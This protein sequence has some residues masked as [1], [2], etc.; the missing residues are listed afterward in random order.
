[1]EI[2]SRPSS[3]RSLLLCLTLGLNLA[4]AADGEPRHALA[5]H[6]E[7]RYSADFEH[8][9]YVEPNAPQGGTLRLG[10]LGSFD[11]LNPYIIHGV[12]AKGHRLIFESLLARSMDEPFTLYGLI[13][14]SIELAPDRTW[15]VF[16][17]NPA[18][19]FH[20]GSP[21]TADDVL[22]SWELLKSK[23]R[24][25]IRNYYAR[26]SRAEKLASR[27]VRFS[28]RPGEQWEM[29]LIMGL[30]PVL[31]E[32][33]FR[34]RKFDETTLEPPLASGPYR[35]AVVDPGRSITYRRVSPYWGEELPV[36]RGRYNFDQVHYDYYRDANVAL[37][38]FKAG[39]YD[40]RIEA[41]PARWAEGYDHPAVDAGRIVR[42]MLEHG[43][44][45]GMFGLVFNT[46]RPPFDD[47]R[48]R[49]ALAV[50]FDFEWSNR[51]LFHGG[52]EQ[53]RSYFE[54][55]ELAA[56]GP[57]DPGE[58]RLLTPFRDELPEA[59]LTE[60]SVPEE[61]GREGEF[62]DRLRA[63]LNLLAE[64]GWLVQEGRMARTGR[65][66][67]LAFEILLG[68]PQLERVVLPYARNLA[69]AGIQARV[70]TVDSAQYHNRTA[71]FDFDVI[72]NRWGQSLSPGNEQAF[73]WSSQAA[74]TPGSR[75]YAGIQSPAVDHLV[76]LI[77]NART[78]EKLVTSAR[79]LDRAL[80]AGDYVI[81]LY[82]SRVDRIAYWTGIERPVVIPLYGFQLDTWWAQPARSSRK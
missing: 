24:P 11:S 23:G 3:T 5:M 34:D 75:N 56:R 31:S 17:L 13:A 57:I 28:F 49:R 33:Y 59:I 20:D 27:R 10:A 7:P 43:R 48:V 2:L 47:T 45:V 14:E 9:Q 44:P 1:M 8:F 72:A 65:A 80:L 18:A 6:G 12:P 21:V 19:R 61:I 38:A 69:R 50:L 81:P 54:N 29:P 25:N 26:V 39:E 35:V 52:Y 79:A 42:V 40:L 58:R 55:S 82:H 60:T 77:A 74:T 41:D 36:N 46:R 71:E 62:R 16:N 53:T 15:V 76:Q 73:Y 68:R 63:A 30:M 37:E 78:R 66:Q 4:A 32:A 64:A 22:F 67:P 51:V 70:R